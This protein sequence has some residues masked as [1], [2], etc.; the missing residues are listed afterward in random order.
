MNHDKTITRLAQGLSQIADSLPCIDFLSQLYP[1]DLMKTAI[2]EVNAYILRFLIRAYDWYREGPWKHILHSLTRPAELR[3]DDIME[4]ISQRTA[5]IKDLASYGG[6]GKIHNMSIK[7]D[8][9][10]T[11][12]E[13]LQTTVSR[14]SNYNQHLRL[15]LMCRSAMY[16]NG[17]NERPAYRHTILSNY[18][19]NI[20]VCHVDARKSA[21][22]SAGSSYA[23]P[24]ISIF[25]LEAPTTFLWLLQASNMDRI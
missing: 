1:T 17:N 7:M 18:E 12:L 11:K 3:Y 10:N 4:A 15:Y 9:V 13:Q 16:F 25:E 2:A 24:S 20:G 21:L 22:P 5:K 23:V 19:I 6:Q 14:E 8:E